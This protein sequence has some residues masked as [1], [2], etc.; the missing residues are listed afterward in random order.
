MMINRSNFSGARRAA[1]LAVALI[2]LACIPTS[3]TPAGQQRRPGRHWVIDGL[4]PKVLRL[5]LQATKSA[6]KQGIGKVKMLG[7][8]DFSL[9]STRR[10]F[11]IL[12]LEQGIVRFNELVAHGKGS[13]DKWATSFSN[14][15]KSLKSSLGL[16]LTEFTYQG[17]NGYSLRLRGLEPGIN[18]KARSRAIVIHGAPYISQGTIDKLGYLGRSWGCPAVSDSV[19]KPLIDTLKGGNLIFAYYPDDDWLSTSRFL[20]ED[21]D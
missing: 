16:Y 15:S 17:D 8:I 6:S 19:A 20:K 4:N 2:L 12:D 3:V 11:W 21:H 13:G 9:P 1:S 5:A 10:R 18:D 7:I 14:E